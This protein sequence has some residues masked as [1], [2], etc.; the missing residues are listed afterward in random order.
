MLVRK[1]Q[2]WEQGG[3]TYER[4]R[5]KDWGAKA[6]SGYQQQRVLDAAIEYKLRAPHQHPHTTHTLVSS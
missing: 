3:S 1:E 2:G 6:V 5:E 4:E